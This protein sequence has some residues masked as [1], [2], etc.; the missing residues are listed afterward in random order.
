MQSPIT[1]VTIF[2]GTADTLALRTGPLGPPPGYYYAL[3][4]ST[5]GAHHPTVS[6]PDQPDYVPAFDDPPTYATL[7]DGNVSMTM[8]QW[9]AWAAGGDDDAYQLACIAANLGL[10]LA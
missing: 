8:D 5:P 2:P 6:T 1:P 3:Q 10:T 7:K 4:Q 9:S